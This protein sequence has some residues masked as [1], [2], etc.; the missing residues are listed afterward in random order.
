MPTLTLTLTHP[1]GAPSRQ[2]VAVDVQGP[3]RSFGQ[4][5]TLDFTVAED[6]SL[7]SDAAN[8]ANPLRENCRVEL[9]RDG[10]VL[11]RGYAY[12][13][14]RTQTAWGEQAIKA[15]CKDRLGK[16]EKTLAGI[17]AHCL[18]TV[19]CPTAGFGRSVDGSP[20]T[21]VMIPLQLADQRAGYDQVDAEWPVY[22][23][24]AAATDTPSSA[25]P[26]LAKSVM[27]AT[28]LW[29]D[30][31]DSST[32]PIQVEDWTVFTAPGFAQLGSELVQYEYA[33]PQSPAAGN[34]GYL[35]NISRGALGSTAAAHLAGTACCQRCLK[36]LSP[37][38]LTALTY[39]AG[40]PVAAGDYR[41]KVTD[42]RFDFSYDPS[43]LPA[44]NGYYGAYDED[45]SAGVTLASLATGLLKFD[46]ALGGPGLSDG[47]I[48][49]SGLD[50]I[51][52]S[53]YQVDSEQ[54]T[55]ETL[56]ALIDEVALDR[57]G[58]GRRPIGLYYDS[59]GDK[60]VLASLAQG[61]PDCY[62]RSAQD[63]TEQVGLD[64]L[65]S[66]VAVRF[67]SDDPCQLISQDRMWHKAVGEQV[68]TLP[69]PND[70]YVTNVM[71]CAQDRM[72]AAGWQ[73]DGTVTHASPYLRFL[74]DGQ[75]GTGWGLEFD[76]GIAAHD[77]EAPAA[78]LYA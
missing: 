25:S 71:Y 37:R 50:F 3:Q 68:N 45:N 10:V 56:Q 67:A 12:Q 19:E 61:A 30:L 8:P 44:L 11:F 7:L 13:L 36:T 77:A 48:D 4:A 31:D 18:F 43:G 40:D 62:M 35:A 39:G 72:L 26:W 74:T 65:Y 24:F 58:F 34:V 22:P 41:I 47:Q 57:R 51:P 28:E 55:L 66:A 52:V 70:T 1:S 42:G 17:G 73:P 75:G 49:V 33:Y 2:V 21:T 63:V 5:A 32:G 38:I 23:K 78:V 20:T 9:A 6:Y 54:G 46:R 64:N 76:K 14:E 59:D 15:S 53:R 69:S 27:P 16:W 29:A 60:A